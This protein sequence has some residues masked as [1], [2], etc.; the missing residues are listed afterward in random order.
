VKHGTGDLSQLQGIFVGHGLAAHIEPV[1]NQLPLLTHGIHG[2]HHPDRFPAQFQSRTLRGH[3]VP[4]AARHAVLG[5]VDAAGV[6]AAVE[7]AQVHVHSCAVLGHVA[8]G[9]IIRGHE[10]L[11]DVFAQGRLPGHA[12]SGVGGREFGK[13]PCQGHYQITMKTHVRGHS[14]QHDIQDNKPET[15]IHDHLLRAEP[16]ATNMTTAAPKTNSPANS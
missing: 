11:D 12:P 8:A 5:G 4:T 1:E 13:G 7:E 15:Q 6:G 10:H 3:L 14:R 2:P 16:K 9:Q